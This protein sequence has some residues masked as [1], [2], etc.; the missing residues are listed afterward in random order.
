MFKGTD[1][2]NIE[3]MYY[4]G[5]CPYKKGQLKFIESP[6]SYCKKSGYKI[7]LKM[8]C[9]MSN[10]KEE[11]VLLDAKDITWY[12]INLIGVNKNL[13]YYDDTLVLDFDL[14]NTAPTARVDVDSPVVDWD[15]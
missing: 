11:K 6:C 5:S 10:G 12:I 9:D 4:C 3:S 15:Y 14:D 2:G 8:I 7:Y 13:E 1:R